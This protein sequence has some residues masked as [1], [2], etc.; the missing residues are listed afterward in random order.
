MSKEVKGQVLVIGAGPAGYSAA[1]R[2]AD[3]G[4]DVVL[5]EKH[6]TLGGVCLNVGCIPSKALLHVAKVIEEAEEISHH[7]V[8]F[9]K[10]N[11]ELDKVGSYKDGV[12]KKTNRWF[13]C[14]G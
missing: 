12:V 8:N 3:L 13:I 14:Y 4:F 9:S 2:S 1:F 5:V 7:G 10:P 11:I 6:N